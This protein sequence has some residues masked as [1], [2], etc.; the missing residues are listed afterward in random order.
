MLQVSEEL[1]LSTE[2]LIFACELSITI[3]E[4]RTALEGALEIEISQKEVRQAIEQ[5]KV[6]YAN[7]QLAI[8]LE[9]LGGGYQFLTKKKYHQ[10]VNQLL[11]QRSK[12]KLSQAAMET[13]A[14]IAYRQPITKLE[15]EQIRGVNCDYTIQRLLEKELISIAGKDDTVGRPLLYVTSTLFM[16]Y[17][18]INSVAE[19]PQLKDFATEQNTIGDVTES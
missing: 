4:I 12:K 2:A 6:K 9:E 10:V 16:D 19:L 5:I 13:L 14:I 8:S 18:G 3:E 15:I 1:V 17:F 11:A 7:P